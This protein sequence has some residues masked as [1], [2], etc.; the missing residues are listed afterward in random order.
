MS[1]SPTNQQTAL[2]P[3]HGTVSL[4]KI[5]AT[6]D[7]NIDHHLARIVAGNAGNETRFYLFNQREF[8]DFD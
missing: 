8:I 5:A 7:N 3:L 1:S 6:T 2:P 4:P